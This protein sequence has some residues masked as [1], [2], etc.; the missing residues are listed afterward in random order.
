[1]RLK[2]VSGPTSEPVTL[3]EAT[4]HLRID[5]SEDD[6]LVAA[7]I[8]AAREWAEA[9]TRRAFGTQTY[10]I[11]FDGWPRFPLD[12]PRAPLQSVTGI[13]YTDED[14]DETELASTNY[15]VDTA[16]QPGRIALKS[17]AVLPSVTLQEINGVRVR[18]VAGDANTPE[19]AKTAML[20]LLGDLY[21]N[22]ENTAIGA[23]LAVQAIPFGVREL[24]WPLRVL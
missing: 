18:F 13:F 23:G 9:F 16:S 21:E 4:A 6:A 14:G 17:T 15:I 10:D 8:S 19:M 24:L 20:L 5:Y 22:R 3:S 2:L 1:M 7:Q 12:L 11:Y